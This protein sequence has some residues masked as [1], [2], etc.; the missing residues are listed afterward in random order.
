[1]IAGRDAFFRGVSPAVR[2]DEWVLGEAMVQRVNEYRVH[3]N[4][5]YSIDINYRCFETC[6]CRTALLTNRVPG[7]EKIFTDKEHCRYYNTAE[8]CS[9]VLR[10]MIAH[11]TDTE[12]MAYRAYEHVRKNHTYLNRARTI[13]E[14]MR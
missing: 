4:R 5:S 11:P 8:E 7:I 13:M 14:R 2:I 12:L 10:D 3:V 9:I 1:M 6:G